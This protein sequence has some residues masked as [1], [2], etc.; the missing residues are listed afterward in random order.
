MRKL[1][2]ALSVLVFSASAASQSIGVAPSDYQMRDVNP[3]E[4]VDFTVYL[5]VSGTSENF[6]V[7]PTMSSPSSGFVFNDEGFIDADSYSE[8]EVQSWINWD[9]ESFKVNPKT[10]QTYT[11]PNGAQVVAEGKMEGTLQVPSSAEP[12]YHSVE[13]GISPQF[14]RGSGF[15]ASILGLAR[16]D[17]SFRVPGQ[18]ERSVEISDFSARRVAEDRV[19][20]V[21]T[22]ENTG[23]VTTGV[24][25][26]S[27]EVI[28]QGRSIGSAQVG[29]ATL[30]PGE[31][32]RVE[33]LW[34]KDGLEGGNYRVR[35]SADYRTGKAFF[36]ETVTITQAPRDPIQVE[37][38]DNQDRDEPQQAST[39]VLLVLVAFLGI[40]S[41]LYA[42]GLD[43]LWAFV[44]AGAAGI[45]IFIIT[46]GLSLYMLLLMVTGA[47]LLVYLNW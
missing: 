21:Y 37:E 16:M 4:E 17:F 38:P 10:S 2:L 47:G 46:S 35:G 30:S 18:A 34:V 20:F 36:D 13:I 28:S 3:G 7:K 23:T 33:T 29:S 43:M 39:P 24:V 22:M 6:T 1:F 40:G 41:V 11:L 44:I 27:F 25:G 32:R 9:K 8:Q 42:F 19:Q 15:G 26:G 14:P 45:A 31:E 5:S 12:G